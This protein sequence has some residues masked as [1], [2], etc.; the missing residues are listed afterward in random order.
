[1]CWK[2]K[3]ADQWKERIVFLGENMEVLDAKLWAVSEAL[4]IAKKR[5]NMVNRSATI[6]CDSQK[7]LK[8]IAFSPTYQGNRFLQGLICQKAQELQQNRY[9]IIFE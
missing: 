3:P 1:M 4:D 7:A 6:F 5:I 8:V 2:D 9:S